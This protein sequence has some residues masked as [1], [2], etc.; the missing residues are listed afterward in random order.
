LAYS[1]AKGRFNIGQEKHLKLEV[2]AGNDRGCDGYI[3]RQQPVRFFAQIDICHIAEN[4]RFSWCF[5]QDG[6][7]SQLQH[8][9][10]RSHD[11]P[12]ISID[13]EKKQVGMDITFVTSTN[14]DKQGHALLSK[15]GMAFRKKSQDLG[16]I[17][18][19]AKKS[20]LAR[21]NKRIR[22]V[23]FHAESRKELKCELLD[24][25]FQTDRAKVAALVFKLM[26]NT[27]VG[28][29]IFCR[30]Y[31]GQ[32]KK[33]EMVYNPRIRKSERVSRLILMKADARID[34]EVAYSGDI[35]AVIGLSSVVIGDTLCDRGLDLVRE[36]PTFPDPV[37]SMSIE[38]KS[39]AEQTKLSLGLQRLA[40]ED[41]AFQG[42]GNPET[43]QTIIS[44]MGELHLH[45]I[46]D[47]LFTEFK[48]EADAGR[49]QIAYRETITTEATGEGKFIRQS[50][51]HG[52]YGHAIIKIEPAE[53]G[54]GGEIVNEIIGG[55]IPKE[56]I[57]PT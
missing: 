5:Q 39:K 19:I 50:G 27:F 22:M 13:Q 2:E 37:I 49:L 3:A 7:A 42:F 6:S 14:D 12:E 33:G 24:A 36:P 38:P 55:V 30:A 35:C 47:H 53:K 29:F 17:L 51:G 23:A 32:L 31:A 28:K 1:R 15:F 48:V 56:Y 25:N 18:R 45:I 16:S 44:G 9:H 11:F 54:K 46:R 4:A 8:R 41:P 34:I 20:A 57:K 43:R 40:E 21:N 10:K 26:T 52:Q